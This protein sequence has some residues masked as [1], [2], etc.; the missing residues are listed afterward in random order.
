M[1]NIA[2][3]IREHPH[4]RPQIKAIVSRKDLDQKQSILEI[5]QLLHTA[6]GPAAAER[7]DAQAAEA[8]VGETAPVTGAS[9]LGALSRGAPRAPAAAVL[10]VQDPLSTYNVADAIGLG[11]PAEISMV[12]ESGLRRSRVQVQVSLKGR[13]ATSSFASTCTASTTSTASTA[14]TRI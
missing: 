1:V 11:P 13:A 10:P 6:F 14:S 2:K 9:V 3:I 5:Q 7:T 8:P 4:L 12:A